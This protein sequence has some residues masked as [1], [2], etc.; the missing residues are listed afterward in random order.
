MEQR[1]TYGAYDSP[2]PMENFNGIDKHF[3]LDQREITKD[4]QQRKTKSAANIIYYT[5]T[6]TYTSYVTVKRLG[7]IS[8]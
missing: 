3:T 5:I 7:P 8:I 6:F 4:A 1:H 2:A